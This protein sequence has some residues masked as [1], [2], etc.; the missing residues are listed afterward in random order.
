MRYHSA[1]A[2]IDVSVPLRTGMV[3]FEGAPDVRIEPAT[4][5]AAGDLAN[6]SRMELGI[7]SRLW[8]E[9]A[10]LRADGPTSERPPPRANAAPTPARRPGPENGWR[11]RRVSGTRRVHLARPATASFQLS[12][13]ALSTRPPFARDGSIRNRSGDVYKPSAI[14]GYDAALRQHILPDLGAA[15]LAD[16][17]RADVQDL[18]DRMLGDGKDPLTI[19][20]AIMPL[21]V[22]YRRALSR[23]EAS[24]NPCAGLELPAVRGKRDRIASPA[25]AADLIAALPEADRAVWA[26]A[27]YAGL[28][29]GELMELRWSD[30]D[31]AAGVIRV[32]RS[33]DPKESEVVQT[34]SRAGWRRVPIAAVLR[35]HLIEHKLGSGRSEGLV[36]SRDGERRL[37]YSGLTRRALKAWAAETARP[38]EDDE[39]AAA[40]EPIGL[41]ECRHTFASLMVAAGV[42]AKALSTYMGHANIAITLDRYGHLM[43]GNEDEAAGLLDAYLARAD[44]AARIASIS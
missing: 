7:H 42:N 12:L 5:I 39:R 20:N 30:V 22:I 6:V 35:D 25:E 41:H 32:E 27:M 8:T 11:T 16:I 33:W 26:T 38:R 29:R 34:K 28:R 15:K 1:V 13:E 36:F 18:A 31:L 3:T 24:V 17:S 10:R 4:R 37:D 23:G 19:R 43:P 9:L 14:R 21:R 40:L 2:W 44:T